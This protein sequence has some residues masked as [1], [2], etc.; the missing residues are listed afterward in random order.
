MLD[1]K[2]ILIVGLVAMNIDENVKNLLFELI[3]IPSIRGNEKPVIQL[4]YN[5]LLPLVDECH[6]VPMD[7]SIMND[8][9]Y[10]FK[11]EN[12]SYRDTCNLECIIKGY[13][14]GKSVLFNAHVDVVPVSAGQ[15]DPFTPI[16]KDGFVFGRGACDDKGQ[17]AALYALVLF[18][19]ESGLRPKG[20]L[21]FHFVVEEENGGNGTLAMLRRGIKADAVI[22]VESSELNI[23]TAVRGAVWFNLE[24]FGKSGHSGS[25]DTVSALQESVQAM[26][27]LRDY[28]DKVLRESR[29]N[30]LFDKF[31]DPMPITFGQLY[32]GDWPATTPAKAVLKGVFGFLP[33]KTR[34]EIQ[35]GMRGIIRAK[36]DAWLREHFNLSFPMLN[37]DGGIID[38]DH[39]LV[40]S[41]R[42]AVKKN[43]YPGDIAAMTAACDA[44]LYHNLTKIP[45]VVFG[46]G[47]VKYAHTNEERIAL[48]EIL[49]A[50][51]ILKD[52]VVSC[53]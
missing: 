43:N 24:V 47:A 8:P 41:L 32:A 33:N 29:G 2:M 3:R 35:E 46:P 17:I 12:F 37:L 52:F 26:A 1:F 38:A 39:P 10:A 5:R 20:D 30:S 53:Y 16:M 36:G 21:I 28:H 15:K 14:G 40:L 13:G 48:K 31:R 44:C 34:S 22:V 9:D 49:S 42:K 27:I 6:L 18:L 19:K 23:I 4:L 25:G 7:N 51:M 50:G 45:T 11:L